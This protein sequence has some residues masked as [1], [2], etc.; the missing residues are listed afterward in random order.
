M[1]HVISKIDRCSR[2]RAG[3]CPIHTCE[4]VECFRGGSAFEREST[5]RNTAFSILPQC[6]FVIQ[7]GVRPAVR[8]GRRSLGGGGGQEGTFA[9]CLVAA[10]SICFVSSR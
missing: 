10:E 2:L 8:R 5:R 9:L 6:D 3:L 4:Y 1:P 7:S